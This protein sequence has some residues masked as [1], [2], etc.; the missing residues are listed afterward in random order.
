MRGPRQVGKTTELKLLV[1]DLLSEGIPPR[2]I[3]YYP[4]DDII[5][6]REL[7]ELIKAFAEA[8]RLQGGSGY[9]LSYA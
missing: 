7:M 2:N 6:F 5:H 4:C 9:L 3:A 8:V 1:K